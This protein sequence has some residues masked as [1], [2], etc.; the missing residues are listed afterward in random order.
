MHVAASAPL[1]VSREDIPTELIAQRRADLTEQA[2]KTGKPP[3]IVEKMV[4]GRM[5]RFYEEVVLGL[6]PFVLN[7]EQRVDQV[8][9]DAEHTVGVPVSVKAFVRFRTGEGIEKRAEQ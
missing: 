3:A 6:Q 9:K 2:Q 7:P 8:L 1:W 4:E 5:R